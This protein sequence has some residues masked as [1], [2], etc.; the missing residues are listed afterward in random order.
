MLR[1]TLFYHHSMLSCL[2]FLQLGTVLADCA[3][4]EPLGTEKLALEEK[5]KVLLEEKRLV[6]E[7]AAKVKAELASLRA[8]LQD[9]SLVEKAPP[10]AAQAGLFTK[11]QVCFCL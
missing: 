4:C 5:N 11:Q 1:F 10:A 9:A 3:S 7:E 2:P 8:Q 6:Q